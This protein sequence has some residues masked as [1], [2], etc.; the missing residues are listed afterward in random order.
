MGYYI[1]N[2]FKKKKKWLPLKAEP[3]IQSVSYQ[4]MSSQDFLRFIFLNDVVG[5]M[6]FK[7][8]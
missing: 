7:K 4:S 3:N 5:T 6:N 2:K 8:Q 1:R